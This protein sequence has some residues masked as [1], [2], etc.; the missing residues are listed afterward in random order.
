MEQMM[1]DGTNK[2][3]DLSSIQDETN[4]NNT[5]QETDL[6]ADKMQQMMEVVLTSR[7]I[8]R[9]QDGTNTTDT[10]QQTDLG[11]VQDGT[12]D[13]SSTNKQTDLGAVQDETNTTDT[14]QQTDLVS[15][16][17]WNR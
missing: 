11:A 7:Q 4:A 2:Q 17:R 12:D 16:T 13:G 10:N 6:A 15:S 14:G 8:W 3:T 1:E 5:E 9:E